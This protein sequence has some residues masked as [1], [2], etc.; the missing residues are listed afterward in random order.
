MLLL[1]LLEQQYFSKQA[2][3]ES[4]NFCNR[5]IPQW[6]GLS[7]SVANSQTTEEFKGTPHLVKTQLKDFS[8]L[9][10]FGF[11]LFLQNSKFTL[12]GVI[13]ACDPVSSKRQ[14]ELFIAS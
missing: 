7:P 6:N 4:L 5:T 11:V 12:P 3:N 14:I 8:C 10:L 1:F 13:I 9:F 2:F